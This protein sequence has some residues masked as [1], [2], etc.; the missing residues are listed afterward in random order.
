MGKTLI[1]SG[2]K[3]LLGNIDNIGENTINKIAEMAFA[4]QIKGAEKLTVRVKTNPSQLAKGIL[5][6]LAIDGQGL[7]MQ[8]DLSME[9]MQMTLN[10]VAVSPWKALMGN[11]KL[12][13]PSQGTACIVF[14]ESDIETAL[15]VDNLNQQLLNYDIYLD[16]HPIKVKFKKV[17]CRIL[18]DGRIAVKA[19]LNIPEKD[20]YKA[21]CLIL[22]P[23]ICA[24]GKGISLESFECTQG[25]ELSPIFLKTILEEAAKILNLIRFKKDGISL[26][27]N[28]LDVQE[29]KLNLGADA[30]ITHLP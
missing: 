24:T 30:G 10:R 12:T 7:V 23:S 18:K 9:Q 25:Q 22:K 29:G 1:I 6:S 20:T 26:D 14:S 4:S 11:V 17:D 16:D 8:H 3:T 2:G 19:K 5:D 21:V 27:V 28:K 15:S 13:Q